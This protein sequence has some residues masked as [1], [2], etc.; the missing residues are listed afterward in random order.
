MLAGYSCPPSWRAGHGP[1]PHSSLY[2]STWRSAQATWNSSR[3]SASTWGVN[4]TLLS[5]K[6]QIQS[7]RSALRTAVGVSSSVAPVPSCSEPVSSPCPDIFAPCRSQSLGT[8]R[9]PARPGALC[10]SRRTDRTRRRWAAASTGTTR[11]QGRK[12]LWPGGPRTADHFP[13]ARE[14]GCMGLS[15]PAPRPIGAAFRA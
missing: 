12:G 15:C 2:R 6:C 7:S 5:V 3:K 13:G 9:N 11:P 14:A 1:Q 10:R 8:P 4:H